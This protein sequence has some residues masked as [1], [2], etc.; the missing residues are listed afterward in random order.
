[1]FF[2]FITAE[3][4]N[5]LILLYSEFLPFH[6]HNSRIHKQP[7]L[8]KSHFLLINSL[9]LQHIPGLL[10]ELL[11][12]IFNCIMQKSCFTLPSRIKQDKLSSLYRKFSNLS[13]ALVHTYPPILIHNPISPPIFL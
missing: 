13:I 10:P 5:L 4:V 1:M 12:V 7:L 3:S 11:P 2:C 9:T 8:K 6:F